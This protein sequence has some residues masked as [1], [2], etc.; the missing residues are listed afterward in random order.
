M[1]ELS[2][3]D[4]ASDG[5]LVIPRSKKKSVA[6]VLGC[7]AFVALGSWLVSI[8][9]PKFDARAK[10]AGWAAIVFFGLLVLP[11]LRLALAR[12]PGLILRRD[13]FVDSSSA[14]P[15]G[16]VP[17]RE[18]RELVVSTVSSQRMLTVKVRDPEP[19]LRRGNLLQRAL[20][21]ANLRLTGSPINL[22]S[23]G[24]RIGFDELVR[25]FR[26]HCERAHAS[27]GPDAPPG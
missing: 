26:E 6:T 5:E 23:N 16:F 7:L 19:Y 9:D 21:R 27:P 8:D 25:L 18:V 13:G 3:V 10:L 4:P 22:T 17:W 1:S 15:A 24:L 11:A 2:P 20:V 14:I 12:S